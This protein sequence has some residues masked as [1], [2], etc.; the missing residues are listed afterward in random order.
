MYPNPTAA[1]NQLS[2]EVKKAGPVTVELLD[3]RGNTLRTVAQE[4]KQEKGTHSLTANVADLPAG[5][6]YFKITTRTG[7]ETQRFVKE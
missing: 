4:A 6:Y 3:G 1:T 2:Y 5:T 7:A